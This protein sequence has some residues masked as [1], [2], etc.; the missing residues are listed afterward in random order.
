[1]QVRGEARANVYYMTALR[2]KKN[3]AVIWA[4]VGARTVEKI[5]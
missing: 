5:C 1:M 2:V 4:P 3:N